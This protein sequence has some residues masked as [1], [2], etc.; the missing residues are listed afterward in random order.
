MVDGEIVLT[1]EVKGPWDALRNAIR[2][3]E[4]Q[5]VVC[6]KG[7]TFERHHRDVLDVVE[8]IIRE[9]AERIHWVLPG[10]WKNTPASRGE[11][12]EGSSTHERDACGIAHWYNNTQGARLAQAGDTA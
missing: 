6:E 3:T 5:I 4:P 7:P 1:F 11:I 8:N 9:E 2:T 10:H 12:P